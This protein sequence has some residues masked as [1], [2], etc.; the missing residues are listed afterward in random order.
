MNRVILS[1]RLT[2]DPEVRYTQSAK[3]VASFTIPLGATINMDGT[4]IMQGAA[5]I[6]VAQ[7]FGID[8]SLAEA[9]ARTVL[10]I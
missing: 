1:G 8:L 9:I 5:V 6:F 7:A 3:K 2:A 4:A 10:C